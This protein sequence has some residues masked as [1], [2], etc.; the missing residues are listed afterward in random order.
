M[1]TIVLAAAGA[2]IGSSFGGALLGISSAIIGKAVGATLGA[3]IDQKLMGSGSETVEVGRVDRFKVMGSREGA[4]VPRL[5]GQMR[6]AGQIIWSS[7]FIENVSTSG[8]GKGLPSGPK[9]DT[10]SYSISLAIALCE[11]EVSRI[12]RV[13]ADGKILSLKGLTWRLYRGDEDQLPDPV[14]DASLPAGT[15]PAYRGTAYIV[16]ENLDLT[17]FGNRIPQFNFEVLRKAGAGTDV[18]IADPSRDIRGV[19]LVPGTGEYSLATDPVTFSDGKGVTRTVNVNNDLGLPDAE[20]ALEQLQTD[21]PNCS[22]VSLIVTWFGDDLRCNTCSLVPKVEQTEKDP[23]NMAWSVSGLTRAAAGEVSYVDGRPGFGGTPTDQSVVQSIQHIKT[24]GKEVM[25]YPFILMDIRAGNALPDPRDP[26]S[27]QP[28]VPWRGRITLSLAPDVSGTVD[29]TAAAAAEVAAFFGTAVPS[30]FVPAGDTVGYTGP[31]EW[32]Y[33]RFIL[34][35]AHLCAL[36]GGVESFCIGSEM[37]GLTQIRSAKA[38]FPAVAELKALAADVRSILGSGTKIGYA[39]DW[40]EYFGYHPSDGS[41]DVLYHLDTLWADPNIDFIGIDNYMPLS[42]WRDGND[43]ADVAAESVYDI[44]YLKSNIEGGEG[45]DWYYANQTARDAQ[46]RTPIEDGAYGDPWVF[47]YKDMHNWWSRPHWNR[48]D[49]VRDLTPTPWAAE[50][51]PIWFTELGCPAVDK[52]TNQPNVFLDPQSIEN[53]LPYYSNGGQDDFIQTRYLQA[54][55]GY[56]GAEENNPVSFVYEEPM[57]DMTHAHVWA[58]DARPWPDFPRRLDVW[59]DGRN[60]A[61]GHWISGRTHLVALADVV[62]AVCERSG[63]EDIDVSKLHGALQGFVIGGTET[64]R[65][66][67]QPLMLTYGFDS[68]DEGGALTFR[69]RHGRISKVLDTLDMVVEGDATETFTLTR[70][71]EAE[72]PDRVRLG[73]ISPEQDYLPTAVEARYPGGNELN[74]SQSEL[75]LALGPREAQTV[76]ERWLSETRIARDQLTFSLPRSDQSVGLGDV[77]SFTRGAREMLF[78][79]DRLEETNARNMEG[80]RIEPGIYIPR[81]R[82]PDLLSRVSTQAESAVYAEFM[83]LPLLTGAEVEH[84]PHIAVTSKPWPGPVAVYAAGADFGYQLNADVL[85]PAI[86][87]ETLTP[88]APAKPGIWSH[89][90]LLVKLSSGTLESRPRIDV[91]NGANVAALRDG[92]AGDWEVFQFETATL[93]A[94]KTYEL[95]GMLRGQAGTDALLPAVWPDGSDFVLLDGS[96]AQIDLALSARGLERHYRVGPAILPYDDPRF[97]HEVHAF[98]GIG[99]RPFSPAHLR[100]AR[101]G[102]GD[103]AVSW[104]RRTRIDGDSWASPNVPLGEASELYHVNI[105]ESGAL[106]REVD[107]ASPDFIYSTTEQAA[108]GAP[109]NLQFEV[110]QVSD[111]FG[112]GLYARIDFDE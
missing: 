75:P 2:A 39:A 80:V 100:A 89:Q 64:A 29:Q 32:S 46:L 7:R 18:E 44:D 38:V 108:D 6:M 106:I 8:G 65:Q 60:Y 69:N 61:R 26:S 33:R 54:M 68:F 27:E 88:L 111:R 104:I 40:S 70:G 76:A 14:I 31:V 10:Y 57:I 83:D 63:L 72:T 53:F 11:G 34:H 36:A 45:F 95:T 97:L 62:K 16:F 17:A 23:E 9:T 91:L 74:T 12:G 109:I 85:R 66:S 77:V 51:K 52:G 103:I 86:M 22:S 112:P 50:S 28:A 82:M 19:A 43:H 56:W 94:P 49:G 67:L 93:I 20:V 92:G 25:F 84:A 81:V 58:W 102:N 48:I 42:D 78:R 30:D 41:G 21:L 37:R 15:A 79:V 87:G 5:Y 4:P 107:P 98:E 110:A 71:P 47:R 59:S 73:F 99:L 24:L 101:L 1:A 3:I 55:L 35:N 96:A 90:N 105:R 13:W